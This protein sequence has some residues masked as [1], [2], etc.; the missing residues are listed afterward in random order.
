MIWPLESG[1]EEGLYFCVKFFGI[2]PI[3][4]Q[5]DIHVYLE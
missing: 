5:E 2:G 4:V 1:R 3:R